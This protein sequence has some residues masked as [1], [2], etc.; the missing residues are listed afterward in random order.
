MPAADTSPRGVLV[1]VDGT[2]VDT[3]Y[4]HAVCWTE[5]LR[6]GGHELPAATVHRA[7]GL[8]SDELLEHLVPDRDRAA[9]DGLHVAHLALYRQYWG[10][11]R[12]LPGAAGLLRAC[13]RLGLRVVL[14]SSASAEELAALRHALDAEDA[15]DGATGSSDTDAGKPHPDILVS[16]LEQGGL[17]SDAAVLVGDAVWDGAAATRAGVGFVGVTCGGTSA[18][19]LRRSGAAEVWRDPQDLLDHLADSAVGA[20]AGRTR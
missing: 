2:L 10:R 17:G 8:G 19:E 4:L 13:K 11:L 5:A 18:T 14:A 12:P 15:I 6:Q 9:D 16:A 1:D 3:T 20:L 7:I